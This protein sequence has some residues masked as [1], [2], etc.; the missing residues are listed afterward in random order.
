MERKRLLFSRLFSRLFPVFFSRATQTLSLLL[1]LLSIPGF[2]FAQR[3]T[4]LPLTSYQAEYDVYNGKRHIGT[5]IR[6]LRQLSDGLYQLQQKSDLK[7][8]FYKD[9][10]EELASF[11]WHGEQLQPARYQYRQQA[12]FS[13][14]SRASIRFP[15]ASDDAS[16]QGV[17]TAR[18]DQDERS[19]PWQ[20][21]LLDPLSYQQ[22]MAYD[23][24]QGKTELSYH[25]VQDTKTRTYHFRVIGTES[26]DTPYGRL[27]ALR[28][29]RVQSDSKKNGTS[30]WLWPE[31]EH[32]LVRLVRLKNGKPFLELQLK[33]YQPTR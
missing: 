31:K 28:V 18:K 7:L 26:V 2:S 27:D 17:I 13:G 4:E 23:L 8:F 10:R 25:F 32:L 6:L 5:G 19:L 11:R 33:K 30:F 16:Q 1:L 22:Q 15:S 29:D 14:D 3:S 24:Q 12:T 20:E 21:G 9:S